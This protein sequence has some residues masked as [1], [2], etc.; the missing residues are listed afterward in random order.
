MIT[1]FQH[2]RNE[3]DASQQLRAGNKLELEHTKKM[4]YDNP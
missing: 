1:M 3:Y 2:K 4:H